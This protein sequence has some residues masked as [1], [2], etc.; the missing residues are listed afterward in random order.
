MAGFGRPSPCDVQAKPAVSESAKIPTVEECQRLDASLRQDL[1]VLDY[2][3]R[4]IVNQILADV[5]QS[6]RDGVSFMRASTTVLL[7]I[8][9]GLLEVTAERSHEVADI[10]GFK[11]IAEDAAQWAKNRKLRYFVAGEG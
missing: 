7:S 4:C 3:V 8:A 2:E 10:E 11:A 6:G 5:D 1:E 9:A